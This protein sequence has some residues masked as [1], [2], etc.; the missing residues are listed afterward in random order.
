LQSISAEL[1][2]V[3]ALI[4]R[5][6][7]DQK[8]KRSNGYSVNKRFTLSWIMFAASGGDAVEEKF[9]RENYGRLEL[10]ERVLMKQIQMLKQ[11][12]K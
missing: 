6:M 7:S 2:R 4:D 1:S 11:I 10:H 12:E 8:M 3:N 9:I 5:E